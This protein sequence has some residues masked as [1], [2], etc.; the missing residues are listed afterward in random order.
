MRKVLFFLLILSTAVSYWLNSGSITVYQGE[1]FPI[2]NLTST[3]CNQYIIQLTYQ[4]EPRS[5]SI[6]IVSSAVTGFKMFLLTFQTYLV[7]LKS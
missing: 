3:E 5:S 2:A 7:I 1:Y 6:I 4:M